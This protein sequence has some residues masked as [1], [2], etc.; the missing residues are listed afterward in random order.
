M[1]ETKQLI[2][3]LAISLAVNVGLVLLCSYALKNWFRDVERYEKRQ[4]DES[5]NK[6]VET[7]KG[8]SEKVAN[9][10]YPP[11]PPPPPSP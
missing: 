10:R 6:A 11:P 1:E 8:F 2:V 4:R 9:L 3:L 7:V 5:I